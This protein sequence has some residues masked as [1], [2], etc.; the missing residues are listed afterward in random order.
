MSDPRRTDQ[1]RYGTVDRDYG[2]RLATC[3]PADDGPIW[4]VNLMKYREVADYGEAGGAGDTAPISGAEADDRY[5]PVEVLAEIGADV[6]FFG[7]V[8]I[9][10]LN[11]EPRWDRVGVV[12]YR[13]RR[14]F[15]EMQQRNDFK[16]QHVHKDAGMEQTIVMGCV[17]IGSPQVSPDQVRPWDQVPNPPSESDGPVMVIHVVSFETDGTDDPAMVTPDEMR[18]YSDAAA[19]VAVEQGVRIAGWFGVE[20]TIVGDGRVWHQVRFNAFPSLAAFLVVVNDPARLEAQQHHRERAIADTYT[21]I[22]RPRID[23]IEEL[24]A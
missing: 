8:E 21:L 19:T 4:M 7:D 2:L 22:T 24:R 9:Q 14:S 12:R 1:V 18:R 10:A 16:A 23:R 17:P 13:T 11:P 20:G 5:A 3:D 15:I 6:A